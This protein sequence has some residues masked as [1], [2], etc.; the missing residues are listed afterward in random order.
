MKRFDLIN[1]DRQQS[2]I[3]TL[4]HPYT[5]TNKKTIF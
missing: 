5:R 4:S 1:Y 2:K 3:T